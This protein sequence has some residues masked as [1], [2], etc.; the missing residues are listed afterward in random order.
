MKKNSNELISREM[1]LGEVIEKYP[2][3]VEIFLKKGLHCVGCFAAN[4]ETLEGGA[5]AHGMDKKQIDALVEEL[6]KSIKKKR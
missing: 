3:S 4:F 2:D 6:N 1:M 5:K